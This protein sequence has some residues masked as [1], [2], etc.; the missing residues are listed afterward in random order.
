MARLPDVIPTGYM[1]NVPISDAIA[2]PLLSPEETR[3]M[4]PTLLLAGGRDFAASALS[5]AHRRLAAA[6]VESELHLFDGL[7]HAFFMWPDMPESIEAYRLIAQFFD[8]HLS[9][10]SA[11]SPQE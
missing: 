1:A 9:A 5:L 4:P 2:Y 11:G 3:A 8:R 7:P 6:G 10:D